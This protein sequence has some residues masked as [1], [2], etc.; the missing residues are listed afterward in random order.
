[1]IEIDSPY[2]QHLL[3]LLQKKY[4][5]IKN[6]MLS[7]N[8]MHDTVFAELVIVIDCE[9]F[10][11]HYNLESLEKKFDESFTNKLL[12]NFHFALGLSISWSESKKI[13]ID[14]EKIKKYAMDIAE[15]FLMYTD[16]EFKKKF[17][18]KELNMN[19]LLWYFDCDNKY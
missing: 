12:N 2:K 18:P 9:K 5:F 8:E 17:E 13:E 6:V 15:L 3:K 14:G 4:P 11:L 16:E 19:R 7:L 10:S 1:M